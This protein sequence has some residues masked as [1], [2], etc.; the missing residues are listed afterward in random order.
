MIKFVTSGKFVDH[1]GGLITRDNL[2]VE[3]KFL[4]LFRE[5]LKFELQGN[6]SASTELFVFGGT[7][8]D[9]DRALKGNNLT[10][11]HKRALSSR[12]PTIT[13]DQ[14]TKLLDLGLYKEWK[15]SRS[16]LP[17][18]DSANV[19]LKRESG[20]SDPFGKVLK[21]EQTKLKQAEKAK[22][23]AQFYSGIEEMGSF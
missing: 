1:E 2:V 19:L 5:Q 8:S 13:S 6:F 7:Y 18:P 20:E 22:E 10:A 12:V 4:S 23:R 21:A 9:Y 3:L 14:L 15:E 17:S 11:K 16:E